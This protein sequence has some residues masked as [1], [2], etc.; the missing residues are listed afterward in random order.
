MNLNSEQ[1]SV[2]EQVEGALLVL[3]PAGSGKTAL[4]AL[5]L[6]K[7]LEAGVLPGDML[8]LTFTNLAARQLRSR[9]ERTSLDA[10][11]NIWIAT[12]HGFCTSLLRME[13]GRV[14]LPCDF[15]IYD[16]DDC[17]DLMA[18]LMREHQLD[19]IPNPHSSNPNESHYTADNVLGLLEKVKSRAGGD[20]LRL[21]GLPDFEFDDA[22]LER[23]CGLYAKEMSARHAFD[24]SDL[25]FYVRAIFQHHNELREKWANRFQFIQVDE[26]QDTHLAEY[27]VIKTLAASRNVAFYGDLDQAIYGWRGSTPFKVR[28]YFRRDFEPTVYS[29][30]LNYRA[31]RMLIGAADSFAQNAYSSRSTKLVAAPSCP[32][33]ERVVIHQAEDGESEGVWIG[34][35]IQAHV[36]ATRCDYKN[37]AVLCRSNKKAEEVGQILSGMAIPCLTAEQYNFFRR[38]EIKDA[39]AALKLLLNPCD[40]S[41]AQKVVL[42]LVEGVGETSVKRI[43]EE[44]RAVGVRLP[45][46]LRAETFIHN[47]PFGHIL[48]DWDSGRILVLDTETTGLSPLEDDVIE[49]AYKQLDGGKASGE[50]AQ[51][52]CTKKAVGRSFLV[53]GISDEMLAAEGVAPA[54][55]F[56]EFFEKAKGALLVAHNVTY[57]LAMI[58]AQAQRLGL[59]MPPF[60]FADTYELAKRFLESESYKLT[61][62]CAHYGL[63]IGEAHR[64][65]G[66]VQSTVS[67]L[68]HLVPEM[69]KNAK[70]RRELVA[71]FRGKF[72][73]AAAMMSRFGKAASVL[74]P[75][76][77]LREMLNALGLMELYRNEPQRLSNLHRLIT[78]FEEQDTSGQPPLE[79]LK[80]LV[81]LAS[82]AKHL[83]Q[84]SAKDNK[85]IVAPIHQSKGLEFDVVLIAG[86]IEGAMPHFYSNEPEEEKRLFYVAMT[87]PK[88]ALYISG[89]RKL[90]TATGKIYE[91]K[92]TPYIQHISAE[93]VEKR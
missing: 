73:S 74:R 65:L 81:Q 43:I 69:R 88:V 87:R 89:F 27:S 83:D 54:V 3:A 71:R 5:R 63:T 23:L 85:V 76:C 29:L 25:I 6:Q 20:A 64:A 31:T 82:L 80:G 15:A 40:V 12:F 33:G 50:W 61:A 67:L 36:A 42:R 52:V 1:K 49:L 28:D 13:A 22:K 35:R 17:R 60:M 45:D 11:R 19:S 72:E 47:D 59:E 77:L 32:R 91:K 66:D 30:P 39:V 62:L 70:K 78:L 34:Q 84:L 75:P 68:Q 55:A 16:E 41:A 92:M 38:Q 8:C 14:G 56:A 53:H 90:V 46:L 57:D 26:I 51:L 10:A 4:L 48:H 37:I 2:V 24:F 93:C 21:T 7:A 86:A 58:Q 44:G 79:A 9:V 18:G